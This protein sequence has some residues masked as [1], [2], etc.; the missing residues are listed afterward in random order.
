MRSAQWI[1]WGQSLSVAVAA[2]CG[3]LVFSQSAA[4]ARLI[5]LAVAIVGIWV[6]ATLL[7]ARSKG[8]KWWRKTLV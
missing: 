4:F 5:A 2:V 1:T 3:V 7:R 8:Q 6:A